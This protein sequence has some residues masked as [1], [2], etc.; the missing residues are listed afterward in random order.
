LIS[1]GKRLRLSVV[2]VLVVASTLGTLRALLWHTDELDFARIIYSI[3]GW[4]LACFW[5]WMFALPLVFGVQTIRWRRIPLWLTLGSCIG[6]L[7]VTMMLLLGIFWAHFPLHPMNA[8]RRYALFP[9]PFFYTCSFAASCLSSLVYLMLL[10]R[11][12]QR[13]STAAKDIKLQSA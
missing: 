6:P 4:N 8:H 1:P 5:G 2:S 3:L 7:V 13:A 10:L 9:V 12:Q 11:A